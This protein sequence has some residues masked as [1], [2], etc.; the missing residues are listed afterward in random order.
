MSFEKVSSDFFFK[1][2]RFLFSLSLSLYFLFFH[3]L[4]KVGLLNAVSKRSSCTEEQRKE[5]GDIAN[6]F[7]WFHNKVPL[8]TN[9]SSKDIA[10]KV[11]KELARGSRLHHQD[12]ASNGS[13]K[14]LRDFGSSR[15][16]DD[17]EGE[18]DSGNESLDEEKEDSFEEPCEL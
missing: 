5:I 17:T 16:E 18:S 2:F 13:G 1:P 4:D 9:E 10:K 12:S 15:S 3:Y 11:E 14:L 6:R 7:R 8:L